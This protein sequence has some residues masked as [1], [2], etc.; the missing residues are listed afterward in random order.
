MRPSKIGL[1]GSENFALACEKRSS[2]LPPVN[3]EDE[4]KE[5]L[6]KVEQRLSQQCNDWQK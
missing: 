4:Q 5:L 6:F 1:Q 3:F 2:I